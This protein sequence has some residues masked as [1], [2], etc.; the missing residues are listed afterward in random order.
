[1]VRQNK[2]SQKIA[3]ISAAVVVA[4]S[5]VG[6]AVY[7]ARDNKTA[8][9]TDNST[10]NQAPA[11]EEE[12]QQAEDNK[13]RIA[14][15]IDKNKSENQSQNGTQAPTKSNGAVTI[16]YAGQY[17]DQ[18][19]I[20]AFMSNVFEDGGT[21]KATLTNGGTTITKETKGF[22][23]VSSTTCT[24]FII[25][26]NELSAGSW[27]IKV[28]YSSNTVTGESGEKTIEVK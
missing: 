19:E 21:C 20:G 14:A 25:P 12:K 17:G 3:L 11:T 10:I 2:K 18:V 5:G 15:D 22:K 28:Q 23:D 27:K 6:Y 16:T 24:P 9:N 13:D 26:G 8:Q 1:M 7:R 4:I